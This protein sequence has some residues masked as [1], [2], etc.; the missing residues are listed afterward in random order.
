M[1][2]AMECFNT[3]GTMLGLTLGGILYDAGGF[4][5]PSLVVGVV[6]LVVGVLATLL[7]GPSHQLAEEEEYQQLG[8]DEDWIFQAVAEE[9]DCCQRPCFICRWP[10]LEVVR[11]QH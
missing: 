9:E 4:Y 11:C 5:L 3:V 1:M 10:V 2:G 6:F 8:E 7:L